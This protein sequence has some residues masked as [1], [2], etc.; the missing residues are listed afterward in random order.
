MP[1][2]IQPT[3]RQ[4]R[5][6]AEL[7]RLREA[8][9]MSGKDAAGLLGINP[10]VISQLESGKAGVSGERVRRLA[11]HYACPDEELIDALAAMGDDRTRGWWEDYR[12]VLPPPFLDLAELEYHA[13]RLRRI[14]IVHIPGL[15]Q[16]EDYARA[17]FSYI[18]PALPPSELE[19][20]V[21]HRMQRK[22]VIDRYPHTEYTVIIHEAALRI[23]VADRKT[24]RAQLRAVLDQSERSHVTV[25]VI[26]FDRDGFGGAGWSMTYAYGPVPQLDTVLQDSPQGSVFVDA[27]AQVS[28]LS[29]LFD[30]GARAAHSPEDSRDLIHGIIQEL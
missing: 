21:A 9:G 20:R 25:R 11:A 27:R 2:R 30:M 23:R 8:A 7:R 13:T 5:L 24:A 14:E 4:T 16:T 1:P 22:M 28:R 26:P 18:A 10:V 15:L 3:A 6:G 17:V 19:P 12:G 29:S